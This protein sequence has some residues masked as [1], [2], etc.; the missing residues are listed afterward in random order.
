MTCLISDLENPRITVSTE[1]TLCACTNHPACI[2]FINESRQSTIPL[3]SSMF[4]CWE[5]QLIN[6][7]SFRAALNGWFTLTSRGWS[8]SKTTIIPLENHGLYLASRDRRDSRDGFQF[9]LER[10]H[11]VGCKDITYQQ[12]SLVRILVLVS[13][14]S[15]IWYQDFIKK[16]SWLPR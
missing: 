12:S 6:N 16:L 5:Y 13:L 7:S 8:S 4:T 15:N 9:I 3:S 2:D 10:L 14:L 11:S 1:I